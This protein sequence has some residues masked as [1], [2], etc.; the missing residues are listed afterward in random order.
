MDAS[1]LISLGEHSCPIPARG[2][3]YEESNHCA[4]EVPLTQIFETPVLIP[5]GG[6]LLSGILH[7][8]TPDFTTRQPGLVAS[9]SWLTV[10]EQMAGL[11]ARRLAALGYA[12]LTFD[13]AGWGESNGGTP[14]TELPAQKIRDIDAATRFLGSLSCVEGKLGYVAICASAMYAAAAIR[15]GTPISALA[16]IAGWFHDTPSVAPFYGGED[17]VAQRLARARDA[18]RRRRETG[19][20]SFVPAYEEGNMQAGM[21]IHMD[22]YAEPE[23][24]RIRAWPN[25]MAEETWNYWLTFDGIRPAEQLTVPTLFVHG[26]ECAL[27]DNVR[28]IH[29]R[30]NAPKRL[31]WHEGFQADYYDRPDLV[32]LSVNAAHEHFSSTL[33]AR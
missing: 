13:F 29:D 20:Y 23:R 25:R 5:T 10:K 18:L 2:I 15:Q 6:E 30:M 26:D 33:G 21:F 3:S 32:D 14:A 31:I 28:G 17:G 27:P 7:R 24:G 4:G 22:Y 12:V 1:G 16:S 8:N 9:G 19:E 11:Y